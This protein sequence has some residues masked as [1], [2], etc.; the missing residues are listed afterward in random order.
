MPGCMACVGGKAPPSA[1]QLMPY[2]FAESLASCLLSRLLLMRPAARAA[3]VT[4]ASDACLVLVHLAWCLV[5]WLTCPTVL[6]QGAAQTC[7]Q[8]SSAGLLP[9][10]QQQLIACTAVSCT[11]FQKPQQTLSR[12]MRRLPALRGGILLIWDSPLKLLIDLQ[13]CRKD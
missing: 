1:P 11:A 7:D 8:V 9:V 5:R 13:G 4:P 2:M 10:R 12:A 6:L 3:A